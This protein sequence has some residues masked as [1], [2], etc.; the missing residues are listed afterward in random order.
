MGSAFVH[1]EHERVAGVGD[2]GLAVR[3]LIDEALAALKPAATTTEE[4]KNRVRA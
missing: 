2:F 3:G 1:G 4:R